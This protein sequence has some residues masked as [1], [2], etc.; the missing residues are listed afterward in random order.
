MRNRFWP[1][2]L[3]LFSASLTAEEPTFEALGQAPVV[4]GDRVRARERALD[5]AMRQ[6]VEQAVATLLPPAALSERAAQLKLHV[7]PR[8]R[9]YVAGYRV[10]E[11]TGDGP[12]F[13]L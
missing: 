1:F 9:D 10:L 2:A 4:G 5:E 8:A 12:M 7:Y 11:E 13:Q 6:A 3:L